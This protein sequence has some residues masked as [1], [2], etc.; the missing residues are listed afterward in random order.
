MSIDSYK[1]GCNISAEEFSFKL[2]K[3]L[4]LQPPGGRQLGPESSV[5]D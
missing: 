1:M 2:I 5:G 4:L 3:Y